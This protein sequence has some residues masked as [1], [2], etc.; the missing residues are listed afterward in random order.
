MTDTSLMLMITIVLVLLAIVLYFFYKNAT[1]KKRNT[2]EK[3]LQPLDVQEVDPDIYTSKPTKREKPEAMQEETFAKQSSVTPTTKTTPTKKA[4]LL[5]KREVP[6]HDK[7]TKNSFKEFAGLRILVAEDNIIN[8]KVITGLLA[9]SGIEIILAQDG[10]EALDILENE[11]DFT[12]I[13]MDAHMPRMDGFEATREIRTNPKYDHIVIVA[14]S[15]DTATDDVKKMNEAGMDEHLEKPLR[16]ETLYDMLYAYT[17]NNTTSE[18]NKTDELMTQPLQIKKG[19][20]ICGGDESFYHEILDAFVSQYADSSTQLQN[21][22]AHHEDKKADKLLLD[23]T[24][25]TANIGA[26]NLKK[27]AEKLKESLK[28]KQ[29]HQDILTEYTKHLDALLKDIRAYK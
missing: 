13:L 10:Q 4:N 7:I 3:T 12:M 22:I 20:E 6:A 18:H 1:L 8:Q 11:H 14:L 19:L 29:D 23:I 24:G 25:I 15:G 9:D 2:A 26:E 21:L 5:R 28:T 16:M 17:S 27:I